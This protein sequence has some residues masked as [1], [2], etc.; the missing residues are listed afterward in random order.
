MA[1]VGKVGFL[2]YGN[3][4]SAI[5]E[6][7]VQ[8][9]ALSGKH[10]LVYDPDAA[11]CESADN[12]GIPVARRPEELAESCDTL[13]LAVKPQRM[14]DALAPLQGLIAPPTLI[15]S[16][17]AGLSIAYFEERLGAGAHIV[18][19]M[20]NTPALVQAGAAGIA[21]NA[22]CTQDDVAVAR[23]IFEAVGAVEIVSEE[24]IDAVTAVSGSGPAYFFYMV[25]CLA[26]AGVSEGLERAAAARL[27]EQ[28]LFGAG[29]LLQSSPES[30]ATLRDRVTSPGGTT[31]AALQRL[32]DLNFASV[33]ESAVHAAAA[34]SRELGA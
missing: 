30:A 13:V 25:E 2:G 18:R 17:A 33:I 28:T 6:G 9:G 5:L 16:I 15:I 20:P 3:M 24:E 8:K 12:I 10:A 26:K 1:S 34:R 27:A 22:N 23:T 11:R 4:G 19:A 21:P 14:D 29:A 7:L 31:E 32:H